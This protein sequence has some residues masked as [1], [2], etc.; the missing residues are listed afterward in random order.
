MNLN[1]D[2]DSMTEEEKR[3]LTETYVS[4]GSTLKKSFVDGIAD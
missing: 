3:K 4:F 1:L 2:L